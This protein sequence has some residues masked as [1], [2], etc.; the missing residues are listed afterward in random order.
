MVKRRHLLLKAIMKLKIG[1]RD[2]HVPVLTQR[3]K[4]VDHGGDQPRQFLALLAGT[5]S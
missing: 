2:G 4:C 3:S 1:R 5:H